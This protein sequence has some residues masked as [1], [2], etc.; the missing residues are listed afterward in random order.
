MKKGV[1]KVN[2]LYRLEQTGMG[3]VVESVESR[4]SSRRKLTEHRVELKCYMY[5]VLCM[6]FVF[7]QAH[8][9]IYS[10][11]TDRTEVGWLLL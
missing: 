7:S 9:V 2:L 5:F 3:K 11:S 10:L 6:Q 4:A 8:H 1:L